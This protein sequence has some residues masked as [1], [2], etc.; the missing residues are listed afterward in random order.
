[1]SLSK[2]LQSHDILS[3]IRGRTYDEIKGILLEK[4]SEY[5]EKNPEEGDTIKHNLESFGLPSDANTI[6]RVQ[7]NI[8]FH[9]AE[10]ILP[11]AGTPKQLADFV[12]NRIDLSQAKDQ[13][14]EAMRKGSVLAA[15]SHFGAVEC[16]IPALSYLNIPTNAVLKF[17]TQNFSDRIH[18]FAN[19]MEESGM[20]APIKFIEIGKPQLNSAFLM[21]R[22]LD[23]K[24]V[25]FTV[26]DEE[27]PHSIPVRLFNKK[28]LGGAGLDRLLKI[29]HRN[30]TILNVF[31]IRTGDNI[32]MRLVPVDIKVEN[33]AQ[34]MFSNLQSVL[35]EHY[36]QWYF[37]HENIPFVD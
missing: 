8:I 25:L 17:S 13:L 19:A 29:A 20:F 7:E 30:V 22:V 15:V 10:K 35:E 18:D 5:Y 9:Y 4:S 37:L 26:F 21:A 2:I 28:V 12:K 33:M 23:R 16:T 3:S 31:M 34:V 32:K 14:E 24:E 1:M 36:E 11:L 27:T 6:K